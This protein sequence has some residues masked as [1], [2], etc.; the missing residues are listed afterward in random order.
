MRQ[1]RVWHRSRLNTTSCFPP[2]SFSVGLV[3][4]LAKRN[5]VVILMS[6]ELMLNGVNVALVAFSRYSP[7]DELA[8][9]IFA[10]F[11][12]TVAAA[13]VAIGLAILLR[14]FARRNTVDA[15]EINLLK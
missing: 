9:H 8:G 7:V 14:I 4:V 15:A 13:E 1:G 5:V 2:D 6:I 12:I 11:I 3:G 10:I